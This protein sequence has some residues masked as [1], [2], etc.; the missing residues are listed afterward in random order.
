MMNPKCYTRFALIM[1]LLAAS[2][3]GI[4]NNVFTTV[5]V[6]P[7]PANASPTAMPTE[8]I[9]RSMTPTMTVPLT[10]SLITSTP[11]PATTLSL[12]PTLSADGARKKFNEL[13]TTNG[14]CLLPCLW[15]MTPAKTTSQ[16]AMTLLAPL[17]SLSNFHVFKP[18]A[19]SIDIYDRLKDDRILSVYISYLTNNDKVNSIL[20]ISRAMDK[21]VDEKGFRDIFNSTDFGERL[22]N[23]ML[24]QVLDSLGQPSSVLMTT[25]GEFPPPR[26]GQG[27]FKII[28]LYP[29]QGIAVQ[30]TTEMQMVGKNVQ[31]CLANA[32]VEMEF[33]P[34]GNIDAFYEQLDLTDWKRR[35]EN[36]KPIEEVTSMSVEE[37]YLA[38]RQPT[39]QCLQTPADLWPLPEK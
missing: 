12:V 35:L 19:G 22:N 28:L 17:G 3:C 18:E 33:F 10:P 23:F 13:L 15:G 24:H 2:S 21:L 36:Y 6:I 5:P 20:F 8:M 1:I 26:Y 9:V 11:L 31:G 34:E 32:H 29:E 25:F 7:T 38:F 30:Y 4:T 39:E 27:H 37:F 16:E 14:D